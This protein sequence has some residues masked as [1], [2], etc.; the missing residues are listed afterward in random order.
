MQLFFL[1]MGRIKQNSAQISSETCIFRQFINHSWK[2]DWMF[3]GLPIPVSMAFWPPPPFCNNNEKWLSWLRGIQKP[4]SE[5]QSKSLWQISLQW[6]QVKQPI[7]GNTKRMF[8][9]DVGGNMSQWCRLMV[10][11]LKPVTLRCCSL[12]SVD[13]LWASKFDWYA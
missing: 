5:K 2:K 7:L 8:Y 12:D 4:I 11:H 1:Q 9:F 13:S 6:R 10:N 3:E